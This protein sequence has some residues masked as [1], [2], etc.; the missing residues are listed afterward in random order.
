[1]MTEMSANSLVIDDISH[2]EAERLLAIYKPAV[3]CAGI[4]EKFAIQKWGVPSKQ[5]H[6]YDYGGPYA[7]FQGAVNF[8]RDIDRMVNTQIWSFIEPP[9]E[10]QG[11]PTLEATFVAA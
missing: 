7:G 8:Y 1:M 11:K 9:W 10:S 2:H 4:K 6:S 3:F 5:L